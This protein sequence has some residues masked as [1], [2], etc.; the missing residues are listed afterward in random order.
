MNRNG[1][2]DARRI[3]TLEIRTPVSGLVVGVG[4][5]GECR[6]GRVVVVSENASPLLTRLVVV[7]RI[8]SGVGA[9]VVDLHAGPGARVSRVHVFG[10]AAPDGGGAD[11]LAQGTATVPGVDLVAGGVEAAGADARVDDGCCKEFGVCGCHDVL[12]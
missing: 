1:V 12:R 4:R 7:L 10:D 6:H 8:E 9:A 11:D 3:D 2:S 5:V